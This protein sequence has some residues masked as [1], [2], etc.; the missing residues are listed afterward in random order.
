MD[1]FSR[2][3]AGNGERARCGQE[4]RAL[5]GRAELPGGASDVGGDFVPSLNIVRRDRASTEPGPGVRERR[6]RLGQICRVAPV[7]TER[8]NTADRQREIRVSRSHYC[9]CL[10]DLNIKSIQKQLLVTLYK[11]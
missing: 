6:E 3:G 1:Y 4:Y 11:V 7:C 2:V 8:G 9:Q 10:S 5:I